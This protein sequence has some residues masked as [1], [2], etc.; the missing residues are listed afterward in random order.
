MKNM[1]SYANPSEKLQLLK[2][3]LR[4]LREERAEELKHD[5]S[6]PRKVVESWKQVVTYLRSGEAEKNSPDFWS[7]V[8]SGI[9]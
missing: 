1:P 5:F 7:S 8:C 9:N 4:I 6:G 3:R 2:D